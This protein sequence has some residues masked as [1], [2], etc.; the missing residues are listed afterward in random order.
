METW[1]LIFWLSLGRAGGPATAEFS[2]K[3]RCEVAGETI[4]SAQRFRGGWKGENYG[5]YVCVKK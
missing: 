2:S 3:D 4:L 5:N 1:V